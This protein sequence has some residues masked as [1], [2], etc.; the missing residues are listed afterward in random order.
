[1][2][3]EKLCYECKVVKPLEEFGKKSSRKDGLESVCKHCLKLKRMLHPRRKYTPIEID[4]TATKKCVDCHIEKSYSAF[5]KNPTRKDGYNTRCKTCL[6]IARK[7]H[8]HT[9]KKRP[10]KT[11]A[12]TMTLK[13]ASITEKDYLE[14]LEKQQGKCAICG[15]LETSLDNYRKADKR[16]SID[17]CHKTGNFRGLLCTKCNVGLGM[18][19]DDSE[20]LQRAIDYLE[21]RMY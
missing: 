4:A 19:G 9:F 7:S 8:K 10:K 17:H 21:S 16:L 5:D 6:K 11:K 1:M 13:L 3:A 2:Q 20:M 12:F 14:Q 15:K 18:F